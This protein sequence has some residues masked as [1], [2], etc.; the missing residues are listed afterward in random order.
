MALRFVGSVSDWTRAISHCIMARMK[1]G[2]V[3]IAIGGLAALALWGCGARADNPDRYRAIDGA[4]RQVM[5]APNDH[6]RQ[7]GVLMLADAVEA[8]QGQGKDDTGAQAV[9]ASMDTFNERGC[10]SASG[11]SAVKG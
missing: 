7:L 6:E 4:I 11:H 9:E 5:C 8:Y 2:H 3:G 1:L 10:G